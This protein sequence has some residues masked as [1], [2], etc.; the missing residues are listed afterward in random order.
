MYSAIVGSS[1]G[2]QLLMAILNF[3]NPVSTMLIILLLLYFNIRF[4]F[5]SGEFPNAIGNLWDEW[6]NDPSNGSQNQS[7]RTYGEAQYYIVYEFEF[8]GTPLDRFQFNDQ[9]EI[10]A[11]VRQI[12]ITFAKMERELHFEHR[13]LH[14]GNVL[15]SRKQN[16]GTVNGSRRISVSDCGLKVTVIDF[17]MAHCL[18]SIGE[19]LIYK[20]LSQE[21]WMFDGAEDEQFDPYV[22]MREVTG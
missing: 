1:V 19:P 17:A 18:G 5:A 14:L 11:V 20:D 10:L 4:F 8:G 9:N 15:V 16:K 7:V 21:D 22:A 3:T 6:R 12:I 2:K 13:D